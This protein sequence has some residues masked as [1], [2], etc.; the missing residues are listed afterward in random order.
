M[1]VVYAA[2]GFLSQN[3]FAK[4]SSDFEEIPHGCM[5]AAAEDSRLGSFAQHRFGSAES[6]IPPC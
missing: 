3:C 1:K 4:N 6:K 5:D 2:R